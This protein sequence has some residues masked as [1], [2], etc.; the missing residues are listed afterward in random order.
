MIATKNPWRYGSAFTYKVYRLCREEN[1]FSPMAIFALHVGRSM[2][3]LGGIV[4]EVLRRWW[5][6]FTVRVFF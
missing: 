4:S 1:R 3:V 2:S 6:S 5:D